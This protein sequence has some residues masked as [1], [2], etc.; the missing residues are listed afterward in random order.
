VLV[1]GIVILLGNCVVCLTRGLPRRLSTWSY[2]SDFG[3]WFEIHVESLI[4]GLLAH[5]NMIIDLTGTLELEIDPVK[6]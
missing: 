4:H 6:P 1:T 5:S 2:V 3:A